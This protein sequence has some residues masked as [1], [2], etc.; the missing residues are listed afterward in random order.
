MRIKKIKKLIAFIL[1]YKVYCE[2]KIKPKSLGGFHLFNSLHYNIKSLFVC[3]YIFTTSHQKKESHTVEVINKKGFKKIFIDKKPNV[4][5]VNKWLPGILT[6]THM[7]QSECFKK[8]PTT[9]IFYSGE[10]SSIGIIEAIK[11]HFF[12][13]KFQASF[14][15][16]DISYSRSYCIFSNTS[17]LKTI[18][19]CRE[20][21]KK[22]RV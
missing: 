13:I 10:D 15:S 22:M 1:K 11:N 8:G 12:F 14:N 16:S 3:R 17:N 7:K 18:W 9:F 21:F 6:N 4:F 2:I 19:F 20:L 5:L